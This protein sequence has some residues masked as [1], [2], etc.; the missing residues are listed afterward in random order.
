MGLPSRQ[1]NHFG[2]GR[3]HL[4]F[5]SVPYRTATGCLFQIPYM[6]GFGGNIVM[7][8]PRMAFPP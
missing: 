1:E 5:W 6:M 7:L 8:L 2:E 3:Y 4:S